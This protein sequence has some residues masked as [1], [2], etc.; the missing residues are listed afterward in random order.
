MSGGE[1]CSAVASNMEIKGP[2]TGGLGGMFLEGGRERVLRSRQTALKKH[3]R[4]I[5]GGEC[6]CGSFW[7]RTPWFVE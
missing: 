5:L 7:E 2:G 6:V 4:R 3:F 1:P